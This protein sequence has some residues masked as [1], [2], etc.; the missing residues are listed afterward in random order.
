MS[1]LPSTDSAAD[2]RAEAAHGKHEQQTGEQEPE[3]ASWYAGYTIAE[4]TGQGL[5]S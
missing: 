5:P 3:W 2:A 4:Q 1:V